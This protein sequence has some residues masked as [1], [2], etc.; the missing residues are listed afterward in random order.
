M[1]PCNPCV[2]PMSLVRVLHAS[3]DAPPVDVYVNNR[4]VISSLPFKNLSGY[5]PLRPGRYNIKVYPA[6]KTSNPV[7]NQN[8]RVV[9]GSVITLAAIN[10]V[11]N[12]ELY[13]IM[14][15][16]KQPRSKKPFVRFAHLSPNAPAVDIRLEDGTLLFR[17]ADYQDVTRYLEVEPGTYTLEVFLA[18]TKR[19]VL[20]VPNVVL[21]PGLMYTVYAV[22]LVNDEPPL[23]TLTVIDSY[24]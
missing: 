18:G 1:Y 21:Q 14:D 2:Q 16:L 17:N 10:K 13:P 15:G 12:I 23:Q 4:K 7:I 9:A 11:K 8:V 3:P 20:T 22:G 6:G 19:K 5:L 24:Y